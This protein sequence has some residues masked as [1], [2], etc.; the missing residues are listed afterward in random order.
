MEKGKGTGTLKIKKGY[1]ECQKPKNLEEFRK[2][3]AVAAHSYLMAQLKY[4]QKMSLRELQPQHF[5]K[6]LGLM[7]GDQD[8]LCL[9][10]RN[11]DGEVV[12]AAEF[13]FF[14]SCDLLTSLRARFC[15][16]WQNGS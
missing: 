12:A 2:R 15:S 1:G 10:V 5:L 13:D 14:L 7:L 3:M 9:E 6:Y 8:V 11:K 16:C 4:P